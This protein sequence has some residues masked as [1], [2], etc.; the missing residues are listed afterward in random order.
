MAKL[1][2]NI[3]NFETRHRA[4]FANLNYEWIHQYFKV[5][6]SDHKALDHPEEYIIKPGGHIFMAELNGEIVGTCALIKMDD[7]RY[8]LAKMGVSPKA[9][10][11][12]IGFMLG[13]AIIEKA[14]E[15]GGKILYLESNTILTPA[16]RLYKKLGFKKIEQHDSPYERCNI[17]MEMQ[18]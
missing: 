16:M 10:G 5:E 13:K 2:I 9:Q 3:V 7:E 12:G 6:E 8:E 11:H 17:Q 14:R 4:D 1:V 15:L 18:L